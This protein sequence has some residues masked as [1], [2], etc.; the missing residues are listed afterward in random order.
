[1]DHKLLLTLL[2]S[3]TICFSYAQKPKKTLAKFN[4]P[5]G[6]CLFFIGQDTGAAGG[7]DGYSDGYC[8]YFDTLIKNKDVVKAF[9]YINVNWSIQPMWINNPTLQ[10]VD[11]RIQAI[12]FVIYD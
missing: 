2:L 9:S 11:S 4:P 10:Q 3:W 1:M 8:D 6:T 5:D 12:C 7:L